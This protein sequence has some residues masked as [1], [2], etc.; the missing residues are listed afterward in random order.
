MRTLEPS[1]T[2]GS[3]SQP[4]PDEPLSHEELDALARQLDL[5]WECAPRVAIG[6]DP[7]PGELTLQS[8]EAALGQGAVLVPVS[9]LRR[10]L[11]TARE[12]RELGS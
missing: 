2:P 12:G 4:R 11:L 8:V 9:L 5:R 6:G 1:S 3:G 10:L 7:L